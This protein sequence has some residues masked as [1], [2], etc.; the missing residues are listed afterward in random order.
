MPRHRRRLSGRS[1]AGATMGNKMV[2][3]AD[4]LLPLP[5]PVLATHRGS[6]VQRQAGGAAGEGTWGRG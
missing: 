4:E 6:A 3:S 2:G 1:G 5:P